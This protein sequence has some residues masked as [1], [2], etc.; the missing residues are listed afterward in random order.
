M[1]FIVTGSNGFIGYNTCRRLVELGE[2]VVGVDDLSSGLA[3]DF[4]PGVQ[5]HVH[6][7]VDADW[8]IRLLRE[9]RPTA[10]IH[11]AALPRVSFSVEQPMLSTDANLMGAISVMNAILKAEL[12]DRTRLV[13]A[14]SSS[15]YGAGVALPTSETHPC[16]PE[17]PYGLAKLQAEGWADMFHR[18]YGLDVVSLRYFNVFGPVGRFGGAYSTVVPAW[19]HH[20]FG[21]PSYKPYLEGDGS[22]SRDFCFIDDVVCANVAAATRKRGFTAEALNIG[23]G[24]AHTLLEVKTAIEQVVGKELALERRPSRIGDVPH[25]LADISA[26]RTELGF[27]PGSDFQAELAS[28]ADWH[29]RTFAAA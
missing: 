7:V 20:L 4:V 18:L 27:N 8:M 21:N 28:T 12:I 2:R 22:Q 14:S 23:R 19:F 15:V 24:R 17:S 16:K 5:Y 11:L 9:V 6:N 26:A 29:R 13:F 1:T 10:V 3:E 25:T